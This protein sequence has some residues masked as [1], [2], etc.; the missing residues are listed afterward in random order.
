MTH[1]H[2]TEARPAQAKAI[3]ESSAS[4]LPRVVFVVLFG[5]ACLP[6]ITPGIALGLGLLL[7]MSLGSPFPGRGA[8]AA[9]KLL[10]VCVVGLGFGI[11]VGVVLTAGLRTLLVTLVTITLTM[12]VGAIL[13]R[14][15][16]VEGDAATLISG[17]TAICGGSAIAALAP[18][19]RASSS[20]I[21]VAMGTV[22]ILN[23]VAL[24]TFPPIGHLLDLTEHEF[25]I[26]AALGIHD[27]SSVVG[28][29]SAYGASALQEA[30]VLK[31]ARALWIV[32]LVSGAVALRFRGAPDQPKT[33]FPW[34][35]LLFVAAAGFR[36]IVPLPGAVYR[37]I[38]DVAKQ[39]LSVTLFLIGS[40]IDRGTVRSVG[41]RPMA[42]GVLLWVFAASTALVIASLAPA[43]F[44][45]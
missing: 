36:S 25:A 12:L 5:V 2:S 11:S 3:A 45:L 33:S 17:G 23:G 13:A 4:R 30:T 19:V 38:V 31:L 10:R 28:A 16:G 32:P 26:W 27:T 43:A 29:A 7:G 20:S 8:K 22:F 24:Y 35:V 15:I 9:G 40:G 1:D 39:G 44:G 42:L 37:V 14:L 6:V 18:A 41:P 34:F 21:A